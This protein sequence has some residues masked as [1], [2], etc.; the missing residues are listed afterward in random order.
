M[1]ELFRFNGGVHPP[2]HKS[3]S[4]RKPIHPAFIPRKLVIPLRQHIG[5]PAKPIVA[6]GEHVL[7]GQ[8]I[9]RAEGYVSTAVH[10]PSS[11]TVTGISLENV[12][13]PSGLPDLCISIETDGKDE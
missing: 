8:M 7:K 9:G 13:H 2:E 12:P 11:G 4:A 3:E 1:R 6:V 5:Q 10:A